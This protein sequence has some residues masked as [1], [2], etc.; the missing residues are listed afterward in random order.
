MYWGFLVVLWT[1]P[2]DSGL[3]RQVLFG[4]ALIF[5]LPDLALRVRAAFRLSYGRMAGTRFSDHLLT[6]WPIYGGSNTPYGNGFGYLARSE[7]KT[8]EELARSQLAGIKLLCLVR[9]VDGRHGT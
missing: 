7:A 2:P 8:E 6:L 4:V 1:T 5:P 3:W 9:L